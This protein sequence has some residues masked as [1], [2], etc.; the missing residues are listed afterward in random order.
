MDWLHFPESLSH[1]LCCPAILSILFNKWRQQLEDVCRTFWPLVSLIRE[2]EKSELFLG[3]TFS[4]SRGFL[5]VGSCFQCDYL[6]VS[7]GVHIPD[8][9]CLIKKTASL[10]MAGLSSKL[11]TTLCHRGYTDVWLASLISNGWRLV[12]NPQKS[13]P[14][15]AFVHRENVSLPHPLPSC[16][17]FLNRWETHH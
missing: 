17:S 8:G 1:K 6:P 3:V 10:T 9:V 15:F 2:E 4:V 7:F 11:R 16:L 13:P 12:V 5:H 14:T